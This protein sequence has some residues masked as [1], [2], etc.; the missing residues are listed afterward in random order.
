MFGNLVPWRRKK[1]REKDEDENSF[2]ICE[3]L[4]KNFFRL[5]FQ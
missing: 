2:L 4:S 3:S 5:N 1:K